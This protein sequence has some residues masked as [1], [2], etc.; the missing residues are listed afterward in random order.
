[1]SSCRAK[2]RADGSGRP[3]RLG[4]RL[5]GDRD[6]PGVGLPHRSPCRVALAPTEAMQV[7]HQAPGAAQ[8]GPEQFLSAAR[9]L[10]EHGPGAAQR[11]AQHPNP[12]N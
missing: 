3:R 11:P 12:V 5:P 8:A 6:Q 7:L 9:R 4:V 1:V 10:A 2:R